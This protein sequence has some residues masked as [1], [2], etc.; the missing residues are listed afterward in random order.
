M[1]LISIPSIATIVYWV[2]NLLKYTFNNSEKFKRFIPLIA[3][4]LG[5]VFG[6]VCFFSLPEI[7]PADNV[8]LAIVIGGAS[9]LSATG[10]HQLLKQLE[11]K[12]R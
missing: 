5:I 8:F 9:G 3:T 6:V 10:S 11:N 4:L 7:I 12:K 1:E 2:I